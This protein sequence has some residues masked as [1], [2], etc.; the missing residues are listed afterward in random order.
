[1]KLETAKALVEK[2]MNKNWKFDG[3]TYNVKELG[4]N[5]AGFDRGVR[6][7]GV[8]E[9]STNRTTGIISEK[10]IGLSKKMTE[11]RTDKEVEQTILHEIAHAI[12]VEIRRSSNHDYFWKQIAEACG[13]SGERCTKVSQTVRNDTYKWYAFCPN[14]GIIAHWTRKPS[15]NK[16]CRTC[17]EQVLIL[18]HTDSRIINL[19]K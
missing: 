5:F 13:H 11:A 4:W 19:N 10:K 15:L 9:Y 6:R 7:L 17:R 8:C 14:H 18:P 1:M 16:L 12:D 2:L 3:K